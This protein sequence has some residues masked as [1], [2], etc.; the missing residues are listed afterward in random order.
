MLKCKYCNNNLK[1]IDIEQFYCENCKKLFHFIKKPKTINKKEEVKIEFNLVDEEENLQENQEVNEIYEQAKEFLYARNFSKAYEFALKGKE[2]NNIKCTYILAVCYEKG[3]GVEKNLFESK[4]LFC[5]IFDKLEQ[6]A[7][8]NDFDAVNMLGNFYYNGF[9]KCL[10]DYNKCIEYY[11]NASENG[12]TMAF[13]NLG[14]CYLRAQGVQK[15]IVKAINCF[16]KGANH[17]NLLC[18]NALG[19]IYFEQEYGFQDYEKSV[20]W[21]KKA[22]NDFNFEAHYYLGLC[23]H[24]GN[25]VI[26]NFDIAV[27]YF[28]KSANNGYRLS[29]QMLDKIKPLESVSKI[30]NTDGNYEDLQKRKMAEKYYLQAKEFHNLMDYRQAFDF[31]MLGSNLGSPKCNFGKA[32]LYESGSGCEKN[33]DLANQLY[34][35]NFDKIFIEAVKDDKNAQSIIGSYYYFGY[36]SQEKNKS[37]AIKWLMKASYQN[38]SNA[39][40]LLG[41]CFYDGFG[42][43]KDIEYATNLIKK[44]AENGNLIAKNLLKSFDMR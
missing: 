40:Y 6:L 25:G 20:Y 43:D 29:K 9:G 1:K 10:I 44:S 13:Y 31:Y 2:K 19:K 5:E 41:A 39:Q 14:N 4:N 23:Y 3:F 28:T 16:E 38:E 30:S 26:K 18:F 11:L 35:E 17:N 8:N 37:K 24:N 27:D 32:L 22:D 15:D 42:V 34:D 21:F 7:Q 33:I 36:G 12:N